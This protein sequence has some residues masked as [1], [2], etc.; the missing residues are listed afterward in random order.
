MIN[1]LLT[2]I[3]NHPIVK[4]LDSLSDI[5]ERRAVGFT[6]LASTFSNSAVKEFENV[7]FTA[8]MIYCTIG[9]NHIHVIGSQSKENFFSLLMNK[10]EDINNKKFWPDKEDLCS[11]IEYELGDFIY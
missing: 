1:D 7:L 9:K 4:N 5:C 2:N 10:Y 3:D 6:A 11:F 8:D